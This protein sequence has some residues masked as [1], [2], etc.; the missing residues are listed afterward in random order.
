MYD[1]LVDFLG[2]SGLCFKDRDSIVEVGIW[3]M[4]VLL[5]ILPI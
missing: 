3:D 5:L 1:R 2:T 4:S